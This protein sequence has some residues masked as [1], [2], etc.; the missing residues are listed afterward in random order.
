LHIRVAT[1][2]AS[3]SLNSRWGA[4]NSSGSKRLHQT[5]KGVSLIFN[6]GTAA[7]GASYF[8]SLQTVARM[9]SVKRI[10]NPVHEIDCCSDTLHGV[11]PRSNHRACSPVPPCGDLH[12]L[13]CREGARLDP[14]DLF[15]H[16]A[17]Y[18]DRILKGIKPQ[19]LPV[20]QSTKSEGI[21]SIKGWQVSGPD[22]YAVAAR[23]DAVHRMQREWGTRRRSLPQRSP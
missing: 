6:P 5:L 20:Q 16:T 7:S 1:A 3:P 23:A 9:L 21:V 2:A 12:F 18:V 11:A 19:D 14:V 4:S 8:S 15:Y 13:T 10:P 22:G 17:R